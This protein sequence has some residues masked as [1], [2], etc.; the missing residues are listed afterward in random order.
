MKNTD[1]P[2][3]ALV[4]ERRSQRPKV[5]GMPNLYRAKGGWRLQVLLDE[6]TL[7]R[8]QEMNEQLAMAVS[9]QVRY[10]I[11]CL[12]RQL[13]SSS[14]GGEKFETAVT[15]DN[16]AP[17]GEGWKKDLTRGI[18]GWQRFDTHEESYW[19]RRIKKDA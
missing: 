9:N 12:Y 4:N 14:T 3:P 6:M 7:A 15:H 17:E 10:G 11:N 16:V 18:D 5:G 8:I 2:E 1:K 19:I 13:I